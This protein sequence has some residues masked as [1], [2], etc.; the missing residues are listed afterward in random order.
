[1]VVGEVA[2]EVVF[3]DFTG[4]NKAGAIAGG[5]GA[6]FTIGALGLTVP[7]FIPIAIAGGVL[8]GAKGQSSVKKTAKNIGSVVEN[9]ANEAGSVVGYVSKGI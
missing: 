5:V 6:L 1:L 4:K 8:A 9:V 3:N 2:G 7:I